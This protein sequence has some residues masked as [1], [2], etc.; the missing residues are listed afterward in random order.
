MSKLVKNTKF[1]DAT[2]YAIEV[3]PFGNSALSNTGATEVKFRLPRQDFLIGN[4]IIFYFNAEADGDAGAD[5]LFMNNIACI[6][7]QYRVRVD[8]Q[9]HQQIREVGLLQCNDDNLR[10]TNE[11]R[12]AWGAIAQGVPAIASSGTSLRYG[13]RLLHNNFLDRII[14]T[15]KIGQVEVEFTLNTTLAEYTD[16]TTAVSE[17][18]ITLMQLHCPYVKSESMVQEWNSKDVLSTY[19]DYDHHRDTSLLT[20]A[21]SHRTIIPTSNKSL[22]GVLIIQRNQ[23]DVNDPNHGGQLYEHVNITNALTDLNFVIDG[24]QVPRRSIN[25]N[26]QV[27]TFGY[28]LEY[29]GMV[30]NDEY[31][32]P[33]FFDGDYDLAT[34]G[35]FVIAFPFNA[36]VGSKSTLSGLNTSTKTGQIELNFASMTASV[37]TQIDIFTRYSKVVKFTADGQTLS[38]K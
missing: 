12:S 10:W 3:T 24:T 14:P 13:M 23:A 31:E 35:I 5:D 17:V 9:E 36:K 22:D 21:S 19:F 26:Q 7:D 38:T 27:E 32:A 34:D 18:D 20:G 15:Y 30:K 2:R 6:W 25:C 1:T 29:A 11:Y 4:D 37:N 8:G 28:L 16:A 33:G